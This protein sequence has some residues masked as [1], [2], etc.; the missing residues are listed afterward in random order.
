MHL[1]DLNNRTPWDQIRTRP[2]RLGVGASHGRM[3]TCLCMARPNE[4]SRSARTMSDA[5]KIS[6]TSPRVRTMSDP[7]EQPM[8][9]S[10]C[11]RRVVREMNRTRRERLPLRTLSQPL[12]Q[13][14]I[15]K[16]IARPNHVG[17]PTHRNNPFA[18]H[19]S[20]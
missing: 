6:I 12:R 1:R 7:N 15:N 10:P 11:T 17:S 20:K 19:A 2:I 8:T 13:T 16:P 5:Q 4:K 9:R 14:H 3:Q 18:V